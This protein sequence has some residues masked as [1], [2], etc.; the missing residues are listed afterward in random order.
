M[1]PSELEIVTKL[2]EEI[3]EKKLKSL[4]TRVAE[5]EKQTSAPPPKAKTKKQTRY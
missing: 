4:R 5:L 3:V 2:V 1:Q